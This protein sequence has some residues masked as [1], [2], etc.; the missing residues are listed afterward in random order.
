MSSLLMD[1]PGWVQSASPG[2]R[3]FR[4]AVHCVIE[5][6]AGDERLR[7]L[8]CMKGGILMALHYDSPRFTTDID[9]ST[10]QA[11]EE[12]IEKEVIERLQA[13]LAIT[14]DK[15]EYDID[16]RVQSY[17]VQPNRKRTFININM[18]IGYAAKGTAQHKRLL[19][20]NSP[21]VVSIDYSFRETI[22]N[23]EVVE[24]GE[25]DSLRVYALSTLVA[26]KLRSLLQQPIRN[27]TRRQD[28]FD[29]NYLLDER[30]ALLKA[31]CMEAV[32]SDLV[33]KCADRDITP[34]QAS[35]DDPRIRELAEADYATLA[36]ELPPNTLPPFEEVFARV[37][38]YYRDLPWPIDA[39]T[40]SV[41]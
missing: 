20:S 31:E 11:F 29:L 33:V 34:T 30:P 24:L 21:A 37:A 19:A 27:R 1:I 7:E 36:D 2:E 15:L 41:D 13:A 5:A 38:D 8:L 3:D 10:P 26:E 25:D 35:F 39:A 14:P 9:F 23:V 40:A 22:P 16:C 6:V 18:R 12:N 32:L 4:R 17:E 28:V